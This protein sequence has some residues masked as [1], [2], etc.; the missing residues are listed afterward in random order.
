MKKNERRWRRRKWNYDVSFLY[1]IKYTTD[2]GDTIQFKRGAT[3]LM[4]KKAKNDMEREL[5]VK[6]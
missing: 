6:Y 5:F 2:L 1:A 4:Q 3:F